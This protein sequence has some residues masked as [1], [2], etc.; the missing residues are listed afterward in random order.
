LTS[1]SWSEKPVYLLVC[2]AS[3]VAGIVMRGKPPSVAALMSTWNGAGGGA[4]VRFAGA[5]VC[6]VAADQPKNVRAT[7]R[8]AAFGVTTVR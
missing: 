3:S 2:P 4:G 6:A 1:R 5:G 7:A 8:T